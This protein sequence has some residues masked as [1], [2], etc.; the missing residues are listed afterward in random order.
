M[1]KN[2]KLKIFYSLF[3]SFFLPNENFEKSRGG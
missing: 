3:A 1:K 2:Q